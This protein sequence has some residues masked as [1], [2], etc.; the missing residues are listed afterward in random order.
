MR[1][2]Q[3]YEESAVQRIFCIC[4]KCRKNFHHSHSSSFDRIKKENFHKTRKHLRNLSSSSCHWPSISSCLVTEGKTVYP[5]PQRHTMLQFQGNLGLGNQWEWERSTFRIA[6]VLMILLQPKDTTIT[7]IFTQDW[8]LQLLPWAHPWD[9][10][11][12]AECSWQ[13][14]VT[15]ESC[16]REKGRTAPL[17]G[18]KGGVPGAMLMIN[19]HISWSG[20]YFGPFSVPYFWLT[21]TLVWHHCT[22]QNGKMRRQ[23]NNQTGT[24]LAAARHKTS[25]WR[26]VFPTE[27]CFFGVGFPTQSC[28]GALRPSLSPHLPMPGHFSDSNEEMLLRLRCGVGSHKSQSCSACQKASE[29]QTY[30]DLRASSDRSLIFLSFSKSM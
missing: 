18:W 25:L 26:Q 29:T 3:R 27:S 17:L 20:R 15:Q 21:C 16:S 9:T 2:L 14:K 4:E 5:A 12:G 10:S 28:L 13:A 11:Q 23:E 30:W 24:W 1:K 22:L 7:V 8:G 6:G 19:G